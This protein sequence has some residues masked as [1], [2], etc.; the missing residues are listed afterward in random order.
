ML[1]IFTDTNEF[2][3][4]GQIKQIP[5]KREYVLHVLDIDKGY[6]DKHYI[7]IDYC[8]YKQLVDLKEGEGR[9]LLYG[10]YHDGH[11]LKYFINEKYIPGEEKY[12]TSCIDG[13]SHYCNYKGEVVE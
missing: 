13:K 3:G 9:Q 1:R 11:I 12:V 7:Q 8:E 4:Y 2:F 5:S 10:L 6:G